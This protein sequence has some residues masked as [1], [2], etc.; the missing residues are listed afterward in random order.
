MKRRISTLGVLLGSLLL[1][2]LVAATKTPVE[3]STHFHEKSQASYIVQGQSA[4][5]AAQAVKLAGGKITHQL[6]IINAVGAGLT[7]AQ[8]AALN[9]LPAV[10]NVYAD[11]ELTTAAAMMTVR[12]SFSAAKYNLSEGSHPWASNW[13]EIGERTSPKQG[14]IHISTRSNGRLSMSG[15]AIERS[16]DLSQAR[17]ATVRL[18]YTGQYRGDLVY[19]ALEISDDNG[20]TWH[21]VGLLNSYGYTE[22]TFVIS[23]YTSAQTKIRL[24][25]HDYR[26]DQTNG[27]FVSISY[28]DIQFRLDYDDQLIEYDQQHNVRDNFDVNDSKYG[29]NGS[30]VWSTPWSVDSLLVHLTKST[31]CVDTSCARIG[32]G[33]TSDLG[34]RWTLLRRSADLRGAYEATLSFSYARLVNGTKPNAFLHAQ[35]STDGEN[36]D[37][38]GSIPI[39][40]SDRKPSRVS[41]D[42]SSHIS[43]NTSIRFIGSGVVDEDFI[44]VDDIEITFDLKADGNYGQ[45]VNAPDLHT[46]GITGDNVTV[47]VIDTGHWS[48]PTLNHDASGNQRVLA[49]YD[50]I[51]DQ[52]LV[53]QPTTDDDSGHASH[54]TSI[55]ANSGQL[56]SGEYGGVAPDVDLVSIKAFDVNGGA[57]YLDVVRAIDW[58]VANKDAFNIRVLN[59]S[60][61]ATPRSYYWDDP[62]NQ[63]VMRA[64]EAGIVVVAAAGNT[65]PDAMTIGVPG[66]V[67]YVI[68]VGA[69]TDNYTEADDRDDRVASFS[70]AGPTYEAFVKPDLVAPGGHLL[71]LMDID[72]RLAIDHETFHNNGDYFM[73]SGTSQATAVVSGIAA[74]MLEADPTLAPDDVKC[75]MMA[76]ARPALTSQGK[77]AFSLFQQ[78]AGLIDAYAAAQDSRTGCANVGMDISADLAGTAHY[79]GN[80]KQDAQGN[81]YLVDENGDS[82]SD[83]YTWTGGWLY[84][85]SN[86]WAESTYWTGTRYSTGGWLY[87]GGWLYSGGWIYSGGWLY[88]ST[89]RWVDDPYW[90]NRFDNTTNWSTSSIAT[91]LWVPQE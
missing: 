39:N 35:V 44:F 80:A 71:G 32:Y 37:T 16:V 53:G 40:R 72:D 4:E 58:A 1:L 12:D 65:G 51:N 56:A 79:Q 85:T 63:A 26:T 6:G 14:E 36:W 61:S 77:L 17:S 91:N 22:S 20:V 13:Q 46:M 54:L 66:N 83:A 7:P 57:S 47:A 30:A 75:R 38:V 60:F 73:M 69:M 45:K 33:S 74:L 43:A 90:I 29:E 55:I 70:A 81:F 42:I 21:E 3:S 27:A 84:A 49:Q 89:F 19:V 86:G 78:G 62:V 15:N 41:Y 88:A 5:A 64:W 8:H 24:T 76:T 9:Q 11:G 18:G 59:L 2:L 25:H 67:P 31:R 68:T 48:Y 82:L 10:T 28:I 50:A 34:D 87:A 52:L 23:D